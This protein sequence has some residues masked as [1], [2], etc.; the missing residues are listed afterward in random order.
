[1]ATIDHLARAA[2]T[3]GTECVSSSLDLFELP[4]VESAIERCYFQEYDPTVAI[5]DSANTVNFS[6]GP[7]EDVSDLNQSYFKVRVKIVKDGGG[8]LDA[9]RNAAPAAGDAA[10]H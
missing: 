10:A 9:F 4:L 2:G 7:S 1:M 3:G 8:N 6:I 5:V